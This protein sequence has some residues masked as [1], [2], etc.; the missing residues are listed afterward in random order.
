MTQKELTDVV[1]VKLPRVHKRKKRNAVKGS[2][3]DERVADLFYKVWPECYRGHAK[4][5]SDLAGI[6]IQQFWRI[7]VGARGVA[8]THY[9]ILSL[10]EGIY[11]ELGPAA[12]RRLGPGFILHPTAEY[13][14]SQGCYRSGHSNGEF[15]ERVYSY[16]RDRNGDSG[17]STQD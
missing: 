16:T 11:N 10:V 3:F 9:H 5:Y 2:I 6:A 8:R 7:K 1:E 17:H 13:R 4:W 14:P 12:V 15:S